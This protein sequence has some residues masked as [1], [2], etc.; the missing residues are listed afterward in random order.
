MRRLWAIAAALAMAA[1]ACSGPGEYRDPS[2]SPSPAPTA[3]ATPPPSA[4]PSA[5]APAEFRVAFINLMS[6]VG[7]DANNTAPGDTFDDRLAAVIEELKAFQPDVVGFNEA[8][9]TKAHGSAAAVLARELHMEIQY[10]R[11]NPWFPG[12]TREQ[13]DALAKQIGFEEGDVILS[14]SAYPIL[15]AEPKWLNPRTSETEGRAGFH[16]VLKGPPSLGDV[17]VYITHL[18]GGGDKLRAQQAQSFISWVGQTRGTGP[19]LVMGDI[20]D[21]AESTTYRVFTAAGLIDPGVAGGAGTCCRESVLG[22]QPALT[23]RT[24]F[25]FTANLPPTQLSLWGDKPHKRAD[26]TL[27]YASDHNG[28]AAVFPL[29]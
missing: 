15:R 11:A 12:Q 7:L 14:R 28:L 21:T 20:G 3:T 27:L 24:D 18:T 2:P 16:V 1:A 5:A 8:T 25:V 22:L 23:Q 13:N 9:V 4:D 10:I 29:K 17:D 19:L 26:G 6:P